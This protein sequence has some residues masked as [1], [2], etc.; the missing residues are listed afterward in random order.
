M[1]TLLIDTV[2]NVRRASV[3]ISVLIINVSLGNF[4]ALYSMINCMAARHS[5][6]VKP[7]LSSQ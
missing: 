1:L 6:Q 7:A 3:N 2:H 5:K 4:N